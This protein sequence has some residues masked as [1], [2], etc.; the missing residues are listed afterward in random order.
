MHRPNR[1]VVFIPPKNFQELRLHQTLILFSEFWHTSIVFSQKYVCDFQTNF[2]FNFICVL[3]FFQKYAMTSI[4]EILKSA[5]IFII[6]QIA[7]IVIKLNCL[8]ENFLSN[9]VTNFW[10]KKFSEEKLFS[11]Y[12]AVAFKISH[13]CCNQSTI[14]NDS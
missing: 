8:A 3:V 4:Q 9:S 1:Q 11:R 13:I 2:C 7:W 5:L 10:K 12:R 14:K 6:S